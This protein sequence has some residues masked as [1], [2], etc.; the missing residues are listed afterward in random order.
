MARSVSASR[1]LPLSLI[2]WCS[3]TTLPLLENSFS[4]RINAIIAKTREMRRGP[5][6]PHLYVVKEDGEPPLRLW[7]LSS[8]I[9]DRAEQMPSYQQYLGQV[10]DKVHRS[11][12][13]MNSIILTTNAGQW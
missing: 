5:Y 3:Q 1:R 9:M 12:A 8:L 6:W 10:K 2:V 7:A 11:L 4:Q 13:A